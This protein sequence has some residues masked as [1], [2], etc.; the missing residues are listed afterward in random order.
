M[1]AFGPLWTLAIV[2]CPF[3]FTAAKEATATIPIVFQVGID[4]IAAGLVSSLARLGGNVTG[5]TNI[6]TE[7]ASKR[8]ELLREL[9]PKATAVA[10]LVNPTSREITEAVS[11]DLQS[12][13]PS[14]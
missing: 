5:I 10:L 11:N 7:L 1:S 3:Q 2:A 4:P 12:T 6:N 9:V 13:A 14:G 8:L